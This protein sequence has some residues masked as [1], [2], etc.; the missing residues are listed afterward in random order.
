MVSAGSDP[1]AR[2]AEPLGGLRG[3][4]ACVLSWRQ[5]S[6]RGPPEPPTLGPGGVAG[7]VAAGWGSGWVPPPVPTSSSVAA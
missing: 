1:P 5:G 3:Q 7:Y 4:H 2:C 6:L